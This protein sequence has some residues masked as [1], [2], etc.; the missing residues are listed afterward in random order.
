MQRPSQKK[1]FFGQGEVAKHFMVARSTAKLAPETNL[2]EDSGNCR[3][4]NNPRN[5]AC[6]SCLFILC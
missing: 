3:T 5:A 6:N 2:F 1:Q 4:K